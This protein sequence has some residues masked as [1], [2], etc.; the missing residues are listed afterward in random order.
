MIIVS[1]PEKW[2]CVFADKDYKKGETI[3]ICEYITIPQAQIEML[4][5]T[6]VNDYWFGLNWDQWDAQLLLW[7]WSLFNHSREP[8][9][10][11]VFEKETL[12]V[13]FVAIKDIENGESIEQS[14]WWMVVTIEERVAVRH[15]NVRKIQ[16]N[17]NTFKYITIIE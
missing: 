16:I 8:N 1:I 9:M 17:E 7:T 2:R 11:P 4:K 5:N 12:R 10:T 15:V 14:Y 13:G 6:V 3:E